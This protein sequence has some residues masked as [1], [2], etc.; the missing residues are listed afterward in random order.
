MKSPQSRHHPRE[1]HALQSQRRADMDRL[2]GQAGMDETWQGRSMRLP[3]V[4][5]TRLQAVLANA[6]EPD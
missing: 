4:A 6:G 3:A 5:K 2:D 1:A